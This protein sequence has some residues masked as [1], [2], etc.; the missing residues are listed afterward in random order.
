MEFNPN[1]TICLNMKADKD[2]VQDSSIFC[3]R[4]VSIEVVGFSTSVENF[5][6]FD[7]GLA[8]KS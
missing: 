8:N 2:S 1:A 3:G 6:P 5:S 4:V 7:F